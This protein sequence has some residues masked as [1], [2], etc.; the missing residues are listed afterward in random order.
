LVR[1]GPLAPV[2]AMADHPVRLGIRQL[3]RF[4]KKAF[5]KRLRLWLRFG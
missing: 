2:V 4:V 5:A 3:P 1:D